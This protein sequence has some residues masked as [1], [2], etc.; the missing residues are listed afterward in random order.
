MAAD[1]LLAIE[2]V[3][4]GAE[5]QVVVA[6]S[7]PAG[8]TVA[9]AL[10]YSGLAARFTEIGPDPKLGVFGRVVRPETPVGAGD[11]VEIYRPLIAD[12]KQVRRRRAASKAAT[13][14]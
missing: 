14:A 4:A 3:Y 5:E 9:Q 11:R 7:V 6:L 12:P 8:T 13:R 1:A 2:V 10:E